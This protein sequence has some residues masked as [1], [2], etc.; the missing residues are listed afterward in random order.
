MVISTAILWLIL[1]KARLIA[2]FQGVLTQLIFD[3]TIQVRLHGS[4]EEGPSS[5]SADSATTVDQEGITPGGES[6]TLMDSTH[7]GSDD[8]TISEGNTQASGTKNISLGNLNNLVASD[9]ENLDNGQLWIMQGSSCRL[10]L[11]SI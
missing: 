8:A 3:R 11:P 9:V 6:E 7:I 1:T 4:M 10:S 5:S 2:R